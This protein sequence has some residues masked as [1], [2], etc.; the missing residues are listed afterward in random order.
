MLV[1]QHPQEAQR[2]HQAAVAC[3]DRR[4]ALGD[5][6][7]HTGRNTASNGARNAHGRSFVGAVIA[8]ERHIVFIV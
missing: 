5:V 6:T 2:I 1:E 4:P 8:Y 3:V 7:A